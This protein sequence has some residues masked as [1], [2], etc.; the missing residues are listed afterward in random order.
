MAA[1]L[2]SDIARDERRRKLVVVLALAVLLAVVLA[3]GFYLGQL[4]VHSGMGK[5]PMSF[6]ALQGEFLLPVMSWREREAEL[7]V[8]QHPA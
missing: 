8:Q 3:V 7:E 5:N 2:D 4:A 6:R 1:R